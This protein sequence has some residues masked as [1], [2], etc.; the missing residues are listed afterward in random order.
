MSRPITVACL[1]LA[2]LITVSAT[3]AERP[4][5]LDGGAASTLESG[6]EAMALTEVDTFY[7]LGGP[8]RQDGR[9]ENQSGQPDWHGWTHED[10]SADPDP[11]WQVSDFQAQNGS[12][13]MWCGTVFPNG[14]HGYGNDWYKSLLFEHTVADNA[15]AATV[16]WQARLRVDVEP[17]YDFVF[18]QVNRGG[19][20]ETLHSYDGVHVVDVDETIVFEPAHYTGAGQDR[21]QLRVRLESDYVWSDEDQLW[22]TDGACQYDDVEVTV[23]G[24]VVDFEDFEDQ[25]SDR[26]LPIAEVGV[27]DYAHIWSYLSD[28]DYC[29]DNYTQ[30]VAFVDDGF[31]VPGTGGTWCITWC[32]GPGGYIVNH[33][34]GLAGS[35]RELDNYVI[36]PALDWPALADAAYLEFEV[37]EHETLAPNSPGIFYMWYV[38]S[39]DTGDPADLD[40][41]MWKSRDYVYYGGPG[42]RVRRETLTNLLEPGVT[43]VQVALRVAELAYDAWNGADG[44]PAPYFDNVRVVAYSVAGPS[45]SAREVDLYNDGF[46]ARGQLDLTNLAGNSVRLD[47]AANVSPP[48]H[49]RNDPG[50]SLVFDASTIR[51]GAVLEG[52]PRVHVRMRANR[53]FRD[54]R[55]LPA[56]FTL[57]QDTYHDMVT[58]WVDADSVFNGT[59]GFVENRWSCDLPDEGFFYPGDVIHYYV[60]A[61]DNALGNIGVSLLPADTTGYASFD[62]YPDLDLYD[63]L[64]IVRALPTVESNN[65]GDQPDVLVWDDQGDPAAHDEWRHMF[66]SL[67]YKEAGNY[68]IFTTRSP[69]S[70]AGNGLGGRATPEQL[71]HYDAVIYTSGVQTRFLLGDGDFQIDPSDDI[72][73][74]ADWLD[75]GGKS[76]L[77]TGDN[78]AS[79][80]S[81]WSAAGTQF[82]ADRVGVDVVSR[83][84]LHYIGFQ[85]TP[86][87]RAFPSNGVIAT[88]DRWVPYGGCPGVNQFDA[89]TAHG[90]T[91]WLAEFT[92]PAGN[93]DVYEYAAASLHNE[94]TT[95]GTVALLPY[96]LTFVYAD[97]GW[98]PPH[99]Y[100]NVSARAVL[101]HDYLAFFGVEPPPPPGV[102]PDAML[103]VSQ[104]PNPFN[105]TT[106][107][108]LDLPHAADVRLRIYD[109]RGALV[110]T[111]LDERLATGRH[112]IPWN[113]T[114]DR[115]AAVASGVYFSETHAGNEVRVQKMA[116]VR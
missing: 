95:N 6:P 69:S 21:I 41:A 96:D 19:V 62:R 100:G 51:S 64:F 28:V 53:V 68:D 12:Y 38:R 59:G 91:W 99:G 73:L 79:E 81:Y 65:N 82:L 56:N 31:V 88:I 66:N 77:L 58:G 45:I 75:L 8:G 110:R 23:D 4:R 15:V 101:L 89:V 71:A 35:D 40:A 105:P 80:L 47:M 9:F 90:D 54:V 24:V 17:I 83:E 103:Q 46:P 76:L 116:L 84:I 44:T 48:E 114:D 49:L 5:L 2:C 72:G 22:D 57:Q 18:L 50:D 61:K 37:Y 30:Q 39:V 107:I 14:D 3:A 27:G 111:L 92:D 11:R 52:P 85:T 26:W 10:A 102:T 20:W 67:R 106:T 33:S 16:R 108:A 32:Y 13:S 78:V 25:T 113:G 97:Q 93:G 87:V 86:L 70:A 36:S 42:Y 7:L 104:Y 63:N 34:G 55:V 115:G 94:A 1:L 60:E 98:F 29:H 74:L 109:L 112:E 43:H